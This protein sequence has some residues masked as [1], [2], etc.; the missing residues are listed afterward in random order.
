MG[1]DGGKTQKVPHVSNVVGHEHSSYSETTWEKK[2]NSKKMLK[3]Y[4]RLCRQFRVVEG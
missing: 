3:Y 1:K 4:N 2:G